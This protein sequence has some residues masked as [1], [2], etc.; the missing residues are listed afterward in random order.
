MDDDVQDGDAE[1]K[2]AQR[3]AHVKECFFQAAFCTKDVSF[4]SKGRSQSGAALLQENGGHEENG[5]D[6]EAD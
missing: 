3:D 4:S 2:T 1:K 6:D 5:D